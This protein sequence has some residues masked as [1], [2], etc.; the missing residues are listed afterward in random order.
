M[1]VPY[2]KGS[3]GPQ[4]L[5]CFLPVCTFHTLQYGGQ[6][7]ATVCWAL[8]ALSPGR[9]R[10]PLHGNETMFT[11][12]FTLLR[13]LHIRH[14]AIPFFILWPATQKERARKGDMRVVAAFLSVFH[15]KVWELLAHHYHQGHRRTMLQ[16]IH[17]TLWCKPDRAGQQLRHILLEALQ[18]KGAMG[19]QP[20]S[21]LASLVFIL[22]LRTS[23][24]FS[25]AVVF[26]RGQVWLLKPG[27][28]DIG[29]PRGQK[30]VL[31][32]RHFSAPRPSAIQLLS[33]PQPS[34]EPFSKAA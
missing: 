17:T 11:S 10:S 5:L 9:W 7:I 8:G 12:G 29:V 34:A 24:D 33:P 21:Y 30:D 16:L 15:F 13:L 26:T 6:H 19:H 32:P 14:A 31:R 18:D 25:G 1:H 23:P 3:Q 28:S 4:L 2:V 27:T 20:S 22:H